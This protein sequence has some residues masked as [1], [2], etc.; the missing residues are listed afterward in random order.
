MSKDEI[1]KEK[2]NFEI[3]KLK[4]FVF[5]LAATIAGSYTLLINLE[6]NIYNKRL[7]IAGAILIF[8]L[9]LAIILLGVIFLYF[10]I[11]GMKEFDE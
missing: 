1:I 7:L 11:I 8:F 2:I 5:I 4:L 3:E 10:Q 9:F 6:S